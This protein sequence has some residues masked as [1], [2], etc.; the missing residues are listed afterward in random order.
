M[1]D[2]KDRY[3]PRTI[4]DPTV[5]FV[6]EEPVFRDRDGATVLRRWPKIPIRAVPADV[7]FGLVA[8]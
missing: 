5:G 3:R 4:G 7:C 6:N 8:G 2:D 1:S